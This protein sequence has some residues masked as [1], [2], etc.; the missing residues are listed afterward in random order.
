MILHRFAIKPTLDS[1]PL[2]QAKKLT[3]ISIGPNVNN[4]STLQ[5]Q[6]PAIEFNLKPQL[7]DATLKTTET[8]KSCIVT[9]TN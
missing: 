6:L 4:K 8:K 7:K 9:L 2:L 3:T 1:W 5:I